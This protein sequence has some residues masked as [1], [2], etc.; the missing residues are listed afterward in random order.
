MPTTNMNVPHENGL[1]DSLGSGAT[2]SYT[3]QHSV[4]IANSF[5]S[6]GMWQDSVAA[7]TVF[8]DAHNKR[9]AAYT[10]GTAEAAGWA[11]HN[12]HNQ[13]GAALR[14][15]STSSAAGGTLRSDGRGSLS[16]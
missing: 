14:T 5:V 15:P 10:F 6:P 8:S 16:H 2:S 12:T 1:V 7:A 4:G 3:P 13:G 9:A 11:N